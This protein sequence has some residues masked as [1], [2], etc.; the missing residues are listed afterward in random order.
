M[1][2]METSPAADS[3]SKVSLRVRRLKETYDRSP[4]ALAFFFTA[5]LFSARPFDAET[6]QAGNLVP[7][8]L[9]RANR[10]QNNLNRWYDARVGRW[11]SE[12]PIGFAGGDGNLYR[13]VGNSTP[14]RS[15]PLGLLSC[16]VTDE[17]YRISSKWQVHAVP[18]QILSPDVSTHPVGGSV[19]PLGKVGCMAKQDI[20][21]KYQC[22]HQGSRHALYRDASISVYIEVSLVPAHDVWV[23]QISI[24]WPVDI[25]FGPAISIT[26]DFATQ[27]DKD[28]AQG[29][30]S[31]YLEPRLREL[32]RPAEAPPIWPTKVRCPF[33][34]D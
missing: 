12:D 8:G 19:V 29:I 11:L 7:G 32:E 17:Y 15:N 3:R 30:C 31:R 6:K 23:K 22:C 1:V 13:Y 10:L 4:V 25:P 2:T 5:R 28:R 18:L 16:T 14:W 24:S 34:E 20:I 9:A 27:E 26:L 33:H 21:A